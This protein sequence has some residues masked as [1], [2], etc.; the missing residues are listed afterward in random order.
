MRSD[1]SLKQWKTRCG[2]AKLVGGAFYIRLAK[3]VVGEGA[4]MPNHCGYNLHVEKYE[5][6]ALNL[7]VHMSQQFTK[8][9]HRF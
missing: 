9:G 4:P 2:T 6:S 8:Q 5:T 7:T 1:G 3:E